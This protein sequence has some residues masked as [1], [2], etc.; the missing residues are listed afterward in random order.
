VL[1]NSRKDSKWSCS[2]YY[3]FN[4]FGILKL[5]Q[6]TKLF[7]K[8][9]S[10]SLQI[11]DIFGFRQRTKYELQNFSNFLIIGKNCAPNWA[12]PSAT[13][14]DPGSD[15]TRA[16]PP[17]TAWTAT[18]AVLRRAVSS[19]CPW[20]SCHPACAAPPT[21]DALSA[22]SSRGMASLK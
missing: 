10:S 2:K 13:V 5:S 15:R 8:F 21:C 9:I 3:N 17:C 1:K 14:T 12:W 6:W 19:G 16:F 7:I 20:L 18:A 11:L 4:S 22:L